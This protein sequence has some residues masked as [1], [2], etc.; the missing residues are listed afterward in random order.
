MLTT[1]TFYLQKLTLTSPTIGG[2]LMGVVPSRTKA[3]ELSYIIS[4]TY[5]ET[6]LVITKSA[7]V[8]IHCVCNEAP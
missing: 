1:G 5:C 2:R 3:T 6:R 4:R 7:A 8:V